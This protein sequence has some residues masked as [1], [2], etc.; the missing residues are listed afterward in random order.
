MSFDFIVA[1]IPPEEIDQQSGVVLVDLQKAL[2]CEPQFRPA[3]S[4]PTILVALP[5]PEEATGI[6][7]Y[8]GW[9]HLCCTS[10]PYPGYRR[11]AK[12]ASR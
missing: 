10:I 5:A 4:D 6:Q 8:S 2:K 3:S 7:S 12:I 11:Q 1:R 9:V